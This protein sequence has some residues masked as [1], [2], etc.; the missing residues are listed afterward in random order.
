MKKILKISSVVLTICALVSLITGCNNGSSSKSAATSDS[1]NSITVGK[2]TTVSTLDPAK[3]E[4]S[5]SIE[6][7]GNALE[8]LYSIKPNGKPELAVAKKVN[9]SNNGLKYTFTIRDNAKWSNGDPVTA[10]DFVYAWQRIANPKN[11]SLFSYQI[12]IASLKNAQDVLSG[13]KPV[14][15]LGVT[16]KDDKTLV[17]Q[18]DHQVPYLPYILAFAPW[19]PLNEKF[20]EKMGDKFALSKENMLFN[21]PY[22]VSD[23]KA[24]GSSI[25]LTKNPKYFDAD[26]V[27]VKNIH[28][29][30][31]SDSQQAAM[32]YENGTVDYVNLTGD[33]VNQYK[34]NKAYRNE[35]GNFESY[36]MVN[37]KKAGLDNLKLRQAIAYSIDRQALTKNILKDGSRPAYNM[38][39]KGLVSNKNGKD[40]SDDA[41]KQFETNKEKAKKLWDEAKKKTSIRTITLTYDQEDDSL[42]NVAPFLKSE[43]ENTLDGLKVNLESVPKKTRI[44][45]ET[46]G[47]YEIAIHR[48]GPDYADPT[49]ILSMYVSNDLSN[50]SKW[51]NA[52]FDK[53]FKE[54]N[55]TLASKPT[56]RW[57]ALL[58][59][60]HILT[61]Q[62]VCIPLYQTGSASLVR[63]NIKNMNQHFTGNLF[64]YKYVTIK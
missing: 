3:A 41:G 9:V 48:W 49:A 24:G 57:Q 59:A 2:T 18:L 40:F 61:E 55:T 31:I 20:V 13:K 63:P 46:S 45:R 25:T 53:L 38:V 33:L 50:Y 43:I 19:A 34:S 54:A 22:V 4:D 52:E 14:T 47:N 8:G 1:K 58:K 6:V 28:F 56:E 42:A 27:K 17:L 12:G 32:A 21:G 51:H 64:E 39:M 37:T 16:A 11:G 60:D 10:H 23:W 7:V 26:K 5:T 29:K 62:A 44:A 15:D 36:L 30:L 35:L